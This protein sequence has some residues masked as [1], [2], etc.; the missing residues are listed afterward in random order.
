MNEECS[1]FDGRPIRDCIP[2]FVER[3][4]AAQLSLSAP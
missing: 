1:G 4:T 3:N 2:L